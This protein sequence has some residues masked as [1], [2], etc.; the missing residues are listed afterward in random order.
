LKLLAEQKE[1]QLLRT[2]HE[3]CQDELKVQT[4]KREEAEQEIKT[5]Y[6]KYTKQGD[7]LERQQRA[8]IALTEKLEE[9]V[10][11]AEDSERTRKIL[12][13]QKNIDDDR[14]EMLER[15]IREASDTALESERKY[16]EASKKLL[17]TEEAL[18]KLEE[19]LEASESEKKQLKQDIRTLMGKLKQT[20]SSTETTSKREDSYESSVR[21]LNARLKNEENR[22]SQAEQNVDKLQKDMEHYKDELMKYKLAN[23][24]LL[25][26]MDATRHQFSA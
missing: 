15:M 13:Q 9:A 19:K 14:I 25:E 6:T 22:R 2:D 21:D 4:A 23:R 24:S 16:E 10:K 11:A 26:D 18:E 5:L 12:D 17:V 1:L 8:S 20:Q 7:E 3:K